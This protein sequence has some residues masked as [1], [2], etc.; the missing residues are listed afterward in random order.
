MK[1]DLRLI[2]PSISSIL[3]KFWRT[4]RLL[5]AGATL[6]LI[7]SSVGSVAVPYFFSRLLD[8][9]ALDQ[10][11]GVIMLLFVG[12]ALLRGLTTIASYA[13]NTLS[14]IIS[15][16][17]EYITGTAF[18]ERLVRKTVAFFIDHNPAEI[19]TARERGQN[20]LQGVVQM[21]FMALIPGAIQI[22]LS[23]AVLGAAVSIEIMLLVIGYGAL[24]IAAT[25]YANTWTRPLL[26]QA[27]AA[28]QENARFVGSA[29]NA[30]ETLRHF[31]GDD[32]ISRRFVEKAL[33]IRKSWGDFAWRR[34]VFALIFG[35]GLAIQLGITFW[36][37]IPRYQAGAISIG[38]V[39]L[40][41][42]LLMQ[43]NQPFQMIGQTIDEIMRAW[44]RFLPFARMWSAP[45]E[46][47]IGASGQFRLTEGR[48][49]FE[50]VRFAY[51]ERQVLEEVD[52]TTARGRLN[53][54]VGPT[55]A[56]KSTLF[57]LALRSLEPQTGRITADGTD[58]AGIPRSQWYA[59][60]GVVP[61]DVLL[62]NDTIEN[63][64]LVGRAFDA[65]RM[66]RALEQAS[67]A[68]FVDGLPEKLATKVGERGLKLSGGERQRVA[69]ARA[70][71]AEPSLLFLDEASSALDEATETAI[72]DELRDLADEVTILAITHRRAVIR[73]SDNVL[74]V[75]APVTET[76]PSLVS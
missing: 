26:D 31:G 59:T 60:I 11:A 41:N 40:I 30:M 61:Q 45:E 20:A 64:I 55:G 5:L 76:E 10:A 1:D 12:Y 8:M 68:D 58:I 66:R 27:I 32:W 44:S 6:V 24:F 33:E 42:T 72:M 48:L 73:A 14:F 17:L 21:A 34:L 23:L 65:G 54:V 36:L 4:S 74:T 62:L 7:I 37:L 57:K 19:Q 46:P 15:Q 43:L 63:N 50:K 69:I 29:V 9:L 49:A 56:G 38:D 16:N 53:F 3:G 70:L 51:G 71:Y 67:V 75:S 22:L 2:L 18:F 28:E 35:G 39:V 47:D 52:F 13:S 25:Y